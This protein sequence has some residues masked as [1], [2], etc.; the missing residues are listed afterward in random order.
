MWSGYGFINQIRSLFK[1]RNQVIWVINILSK[2]VPS[3]CMNNAWVVGNY[4]LFNTHILIAYWLIKYLHPSRPYGL[5]DW[6]DRQ[7]QLNERDF[8]Q[9]LWL[10]QAKWSLYV[11]TLETNVFCLE[12][13]GFA[14]TCQK[15]CG[16]RSEW[17]GNYIWSRN[18]QLILIWI[19]IR[20]DQ[21]SL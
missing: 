9:R 13:W 17:I 11:T 3:R 10:V 7:T 20:T 1:V 2:P 6:P 18:Y 12:T 14:E 5:S 8:S 16:N 21:E 4:E 19:R 15:W